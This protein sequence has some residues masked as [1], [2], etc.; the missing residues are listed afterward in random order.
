MDA[1]LVQSRLGSESLNQYKSAW[2]QAAGM[3]YNANKSHKKSK[4]ISKTE[5]LVDWAIDEIEDNAQT[6]VLMTGLAYM[7]TSQFDGTAG[8]GI[9]TIGKIGLRAVPLIGAAYVAYT[10]YSWLSD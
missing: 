10:V 9:R 6:A 4:S 3:T 5:R 8:I 1:V 2:M 7:A